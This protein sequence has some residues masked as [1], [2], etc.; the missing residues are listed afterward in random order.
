MVLRYSSV[1]DA[2]VVPEY[3]ADMLEAMREVDALTPSC[4]PITPAQNFRAALAEKA[5]HRAMEMV[6]IAG[7]ALAKIE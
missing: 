2:V 5:A 7:A 6:R 3:D 4:P 1:P